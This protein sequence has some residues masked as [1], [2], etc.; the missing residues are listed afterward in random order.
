MPR[1]N[2]LAFFISPSRLRLNFSTII[3]LS[4]AVHFYCSFT[5]SHI[6]NAYRRRK[7][8][9]KCES[10]SKNCARY[11][12][13]LR[14]SYLFERVSLWADE[15]DFCVNVIVYY[16]SD[17]IFHVCV[18]VYVILEILNGSFWTSHLIYLMNFL[19]QNLKVKCFLTNCIHADFI[20]IS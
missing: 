7:F 4:L 3:F 5:L 11:F 10:F 6:N 18:C 16:L 1:K 19:H 9:K 17:L 2:A 8:S 15:V 12:L 14:I 20:V 13:L